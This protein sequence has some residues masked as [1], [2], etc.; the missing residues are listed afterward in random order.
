MGLT[1]NNYVKY[2]KRVERDNR[3]YH[4]Y[5]Q[6]DFEKYIHVW[7]YILLRELECERGFIN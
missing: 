7:Y 6:N 3:K 1:L 2:N 5:H 4:E